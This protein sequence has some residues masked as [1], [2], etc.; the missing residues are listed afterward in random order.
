MK[1]GDH[2]LFYA[3]RGCFFSTVLGPNFY[4]YAPIKKIRSFKLVRIVSKS[5]LDVIDIISHMS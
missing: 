2:I 3:C 5:T 4:V 1:E